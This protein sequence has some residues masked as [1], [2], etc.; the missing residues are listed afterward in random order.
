MH[1]RVGGVEHDCAAEVRDRELGLAECIQRG[2]AQ[3]QRLGV[4]GVH[5]EERISDHACL[6]RLRRSE[7]RATEGYPDCGVFRPCEHGVAQRHRRFLRPAGSKLQ[8]AEEAERPAVARLL[9]NHGPV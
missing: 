7:Q 1:R 9:R 3:E 6:F 4:F 8:Q 5:V 2:A